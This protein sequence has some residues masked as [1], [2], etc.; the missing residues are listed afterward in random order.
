[1]KSVRLSPD[2]EAKLRQAAQLAD[3]SESALIRAAIEEK[4]DTLLRNRLDLHLADIIGSVHGGGGRAE[5][6][7]EVYRELLSEHWEQEKQDYERRLE[8]ERRRAAP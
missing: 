2:L 5:R 1:M 3:L 8:A 7:G 6:S 4:C